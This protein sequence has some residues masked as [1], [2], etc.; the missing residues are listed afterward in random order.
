[1]REKIIFDGKI[2]GPNAHI[3]K[4][5][6]M[7]YAELSDEVPEMELTFESIGTKLVW[8]VTTENSANKQK[9][10]NGYTELIPISLDSD[11]CTNVRIISC[12]EE[13]DLFY[14]QLS[15]RIQAKYLIPMLSSYATTIPW[16]ELVEKGLVRPPKKEVLDI[17]YDAE[18]LDETAKKYGTK[19]ELTKNDIRRAVKAYGEWRKRGGSMFTFYHDSGHSIA[20]KCEYET[21]KKYT[22]NPDYK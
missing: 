1:M 6:R 9:L 13:L 16:R 21:F 19:R 17:I 7:Y 8:I 5:I 10:T 11:S 22:L 2:D 12:R 3:E 18:D 4:D 20:S 14:F 15:Q